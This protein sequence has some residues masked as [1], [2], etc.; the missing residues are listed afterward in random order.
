MAISPRLQQQEGLNAIL[1]NDGFFEGREVFSLDQVARH[2]SA[3]HTVIG[4]AFRATV[5]EYAFQMWNQ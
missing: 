5:T 2:L 1:D 4:S 3:I